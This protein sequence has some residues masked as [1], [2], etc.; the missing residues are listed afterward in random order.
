ML[1]RTTLQENSPWLVMHF[2]DCFTTYVTSL[3]T[4]LHIV[5]VR[6]EP[7]PSSTCQASSPS[8]VVS[9]STVLP[10]PPLFKYHQETDSR[11]TQLLCNGSDSRLFG[12]HFSGM[13]F[14]PILYLDCQL[15]GNGSQIFDLPLLFSWSQ[16]LLPKKK[17][18]G[19][20]C[21]RNILIHKTLNFCRLSP[22]NLTF[23][24]S[25]KF[26]YYYCRRNSCSP[27]LAASTYYLPP[28]SRAFSSETSLPLNFY[29]QCLTAH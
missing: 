25:L 1:P 2:V 13:R 23:P 15:N 21:S 18:T 27:P 26:I 12:L 7:T 4:E 28:S 9:L 8:R 14:F 10:K 11:V 6:T 22:T 5:S 24:K 19:L 29:C 17:E 3:P 20:S 16:T